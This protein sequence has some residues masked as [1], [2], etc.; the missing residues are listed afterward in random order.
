MFFPY[1]LQFLFLE[2][3]IM[4]DDVIFIK[5]V[6]K[7][8]KTIRIKKGLTQLDLSVLANCESNSIYRFEKGLSNPTVKTMF[9]IA[10][11]LEV[12]IEDIVYSDLVLKK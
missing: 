5:E 11:A 2:L 10:R 12:N 1:L 9:H 8:I 7:K 6:G 4:K 3:E